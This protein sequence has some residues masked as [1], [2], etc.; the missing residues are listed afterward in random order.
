MISPIRGIGLLLIA[1]ALGGCATRTACVH[2]PYVEARAAT[3]LTVPE[4]MNAP[5]QRNALRVPERSS[6]TGKLAPESDPCII[7]PPEYFAVAGQPNP[8]GLPVRPSSAAAAGEAPAAPGATRISRE[9]AAFLNKWASSWSARDAEAWFEFYAAD[10][11][12]AGY[13][14]AEEWRAQQRERFL[15]PA[16]TRIDANSVTVEPR[17]DG[18]ARV[19]FI[20]HFGETPNQ[21]SVVKTMVLVP[22]AAGGAAWR[23]VEE[24]IAEVL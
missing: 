17:P 22:R 23:I 10:Y 12:P 19:R 2:G 15:V 11:V 20:Q 21:R 5:D 3:P 9:I 1:V 14:D 13:A 18:S 24:R 16:T 6:V 7:E 4:G 8:D